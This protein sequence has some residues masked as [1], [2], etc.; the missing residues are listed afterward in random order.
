VKRG[1]GLETLVANVR[2]AETAFGALGR[3]LGA[4]GGTFRVVQKAA[5]GLYGLLGPIGTAGTVA[6][7]ALGFGLVKVGQ[8][9][10]KLAKD[11]SAAG[12]QADKLGIPVEKL[13]QMTEG[14]GRIGV[15]AEAAKE[16]IAS[17]QAVVEKSHLDRVTKAIAELTGPPKGDIGRSI[18]NIETVTKAAAGIGPAAD[19]A[20]EQ[21]SKMLGVLPDAA[22]LSVAIKNVNEELDKL[23]V[24]AADPKGLAVLIKE[25][26][27]LKDPTDQARLA[28]Q[29]FKGSVS[30][31]VA[32]VR[33]GG[34]DVAKFGQDPRVTQKQLDQANDLK[35]AINQAA[36]A[37]RRLRATDL[38]NLTPL[39]TQFNKLDAAVTNWVSD[40]FE[41]KISFGQFATDVGSGLLNLA[42]RFGAVGAGLRGL[43]TTPQPGAWQWISDTFNAV[44]AYIAND[45]ALAKDIVVQF[46]T[47]AVPNAWTWISETFASAIAQVLGWINQAIAKLKELIGLRDNASGGSGGGGGGGGGS[48]FAS[49]GRVGG[50]GTGTSDSNLA[51]VSRGEHIMPARAVS[52]PGVLAF[53]E[54][55]RRSGGNLSRVLDGMGH[56]ALGGVVSAPSLAG[57]GGMSNV[58][59]AFPGLPDIVGLRASSGTV[60]E[61]RKAAAMAQVRSGGRKPS[62]YS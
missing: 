62:R 8:A 2:L 61:L 1:I 9:A 42:G 40:V 20:R 49:G 4:L 48:G 29:F 11:I 54:A 45:M 39:I 50:W 5:S 51:W 41:G 60:D 15:S 27:K 26:E 53:L 13:E 52:Q 19:L 21:L 43:T 55:L 14:L 25:M 23:G 31:L 12:A 57:A 28:T 6:A 33:A 35:V 59:I 7:A 18:R 30:D 32:A 36:E 34:A 22:P 56:F 37:S 44:V 16:G 17:F 10:T 46:V 47:T 3:T 58:T 38:L 24:A